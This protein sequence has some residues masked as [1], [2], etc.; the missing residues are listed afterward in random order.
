[1]KNQ[2]MA[3]FAAMKQM[4]QEQQKELASLTSLKQTLREQQAEL[5]SLREALA[6]KTANL[7]AQTV[8]AAA[9]VLPAQVQLKAPDTSRRKMLKGLGL[10]VLAGGA[11]LGVTAATYSPAEAKLSVSPTAKIGAIITRNGASITNIPTS[12]NIGL[13]ASPD[14]SLDAGAT[15]VFSSLSNIGI[16]GIT[17]VDRNSVGTL[18]YSTSGIGVYAVSTSGTGVEAYSTS[19]SGVYGSSSSGI[20]LEGYS[21]SGI[22]VQG[23]AGTGTNAGV[24][25]KNNASTSGIALQIDKG[26]LSVKD[27]GIGSATCTFVHQTTGASSV[28]LINNPLCNNRQ[29]A[30]LFVTHN[31]NPTGTTGSNY[32]KPLGV[33]YAS[34]FWYIYPEDGSVIP[35]GLYFNV[36]II[37][38]GS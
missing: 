31:Y 22:G 3:E 13:L 30:L 18:G 38:R 19:G 11:A 27:A 4:L 28:S 20:G 5:A 17:S 23:V 33:Y 15:G 2:L 36:L 12:P 26:G 14:T 24:S 1:M 16:S 7:P 9:P 21:L 8:T 29:N 32:N 37:N 10:A 35:S 34:G 6:Q 25:A